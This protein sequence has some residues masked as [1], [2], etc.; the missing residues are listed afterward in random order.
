MKKA[1]VASLDH[2]A[3][4][5]QLQPGNLGRYGQRAR[6]KRISSKGEPRWRTLTAIT[7]SLGGGEVHLWPNW[8][9]PSTKPRQGIPGQDEA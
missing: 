5:G 1:T 7:V 3:R 8:Q 6:G 4:L 9:G 2:G